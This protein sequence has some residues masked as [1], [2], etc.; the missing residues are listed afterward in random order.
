MCD[1]PGRQFDAGDHGKDVQLCVRADPPAACSQVC[2]TGRY[3]IVWL[4]SSLAALLQVCNRSIYNYFACF[5]VA[6]ALR[7]ICNDLA[8]VIVATQ[9]AAR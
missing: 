1:L 7:S 6:K 9:L 8:C 5:I 4:V 3:I 2:V